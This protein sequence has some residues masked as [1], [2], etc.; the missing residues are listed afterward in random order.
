M[1]MTKEQIDGLINSLDDEDYDVRRYVEDVLIK[2][3]EQS[4]G[5]LITALNHPNPEIKMQAARILGRMGDK[6]GL[7]PLIQAL[8]DSNPEFRREVSLAINEIVDKNP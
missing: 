3:G 2:L 6:R 8:K 7:N 5:P 1:E 4:I